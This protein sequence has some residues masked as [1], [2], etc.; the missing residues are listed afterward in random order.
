MSGEILIC[1]SKR[2]PVHMSESGMAESVSCYGLEINFLGVQNFRHETCV[3]FSS[4]RIAERKLSFFS[5]LVFIPVA[6]PFL[7]SEEGLY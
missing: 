7:L 6:C 4:E 3:S 1:S 2:T 5:F